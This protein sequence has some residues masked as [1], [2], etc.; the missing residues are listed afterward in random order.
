MFLILKYVSSFQIYSENVFSDQF[1]WI[2]IFPNKFL[3]VCT[4]FL[5]EYMYL[6]DY[7]LK[8]LKKMYQQW[9]DEAPVWRNNKT[10]QLKIT[11]R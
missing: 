4:C 1:V 8:P 10:K 5:I 9:P 2:N 3:I 11:A 6:N 7:E